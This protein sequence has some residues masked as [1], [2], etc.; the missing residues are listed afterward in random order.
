MPEDKAAEAAKLHQT[1][2]MPPLNDVR[3]QVEA[4]QNGPGAPKSDDPKMAEKYRFTIDHPAGGGRRYVGDFVNKVLTIGE[5]KLVGVIRSRQA[6][7]VALESLTPEVFNLFFITSWLSVSLVERP[8]WA[9]DFDK[10]HDTS[11]IEAVFS[12]VASHEKCFFK[13]SEPS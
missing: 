12:E 13:P 5:R 1:L 9:E 4:S 3:A 10:L 7:G 2:S 11:V 6:S 8:K